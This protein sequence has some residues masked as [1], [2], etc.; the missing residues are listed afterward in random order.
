[1]SKVIMSVASARR[2][3]VIWGVSGLVV[4]CLGLH[5]AML[6]QKQGIELSASSAPGLQWKAGK[7]LE[8]SRRA[9]QTGEQPGFALLMEPIAIRSG[10]YGEEVEVAT[11]VESAKGESVRA[12]VSFRIMDDRGRMQSPRT[13]SPAILVGSNASASAGT[14]QIP[15]LADGWYQVRA[16]AVFASS[17]D[18]NETVGAEVASLYLHVRE[19]ETWIVDPD[20]WHTG[21]SVGLGWSEK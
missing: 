20:E 15:A 17:A 12:M 10:L 8:D 21:S 2:D 6:A 7:P 9:G 4:G 19:G 18:T 1:M 14:L 11:E 5:G 13:V 3:T 16:T